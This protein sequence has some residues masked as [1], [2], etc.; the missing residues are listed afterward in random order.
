MA[1]LWILIQ[2]C[3]LF[4]FLTEIIFFFNF[5]APKKHPKSTIN[6]I[7]ITCASYS[8]SSEVICFVWRT[9][10]NLYGLII[11]YVVL[12]CPFWSL[13]SILLLSW[14][15]KTNNNHKKTQTKLIAKVLWKDMREKLNYLLKV[16]RSYESLMRLLNTMWNHGLEV[17]DL[18]ASVYNPIAGRDL[19]LV[20]L[21]CLWG[22]CESW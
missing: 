8:K 16:W 10:W 20:S 9:N 18:W 22:L 19:V 17:S 6:V 7:H 21:S 15:G 11:S 2:T 5:L 14:T 1:L 3:L 4:L 12:S 13:T